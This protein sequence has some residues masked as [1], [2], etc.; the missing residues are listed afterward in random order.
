MK[1]IRPGNTEINLVYVYYLETR[2]SK[3]LRKSDRDMIDFVY[4]KC[5]PWI[6]QTAGYYDKKIGK[7]N[8]NIIKN[9]S[10]FRNYLENLLISYKNCDTISLSFLG[11]ISGITITEGYSNNFKK[12]LNYKTEK[13]IFYFNDLFSYINNKKVLIVSSF[14]EL[15]DIQSKNLKNLYDNY[16]NNITYTYI[17]YPYKFLNDGPDN[18]A[19][20]TI[21]IYKKKIKEE[22]F[23]IALL[24]CG[25]DG[26]ILADFISY[27]GKDVFYIGGHLCLMFGI[28][29]KR[30]KSEKTINRWCDELF[31]KDYENIKDY[32]VENIPEKYRPLN[33]EKI[34]NGC[35]W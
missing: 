1:Y 22:N 13:Y 29:N 25:C 31:Q 28:F 5:I 23:D 30:N 2:L 9:D 32:I 14:S 3:F 11:Y 24:S 6:F 10:N 34:E 26:G 7:I 20:E 21:D 4:N 16:P 33:Y 17:Q 8:P 18:N 27:I 35:Y 19:L 15:I 12:F